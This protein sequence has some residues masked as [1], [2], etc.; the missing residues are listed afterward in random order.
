MAP[1]TPL[2][3]TVR[4]CTAFVAAIL[5]SVSPT[6]YA[7]N[8]S[9]GTLSL[10]GTVNF[11]T[12]PPTLSGGTLVVMPTTTWTSTTP[13]LGGITITGT[14]LSYSGP[15]TLLSL[16]VVD[17]AQIQVS[18]STLTL[19]S[20]PTFSNLVH[21]GAG[22]LVLSGGSNYGTG[23]TYT[24][25]N[26]GLTVVFYPGEITDPIPRQPPPP[27]LELPANRAP[28]AVNRNI[29]FSGAPSSAIV[30][31]NLAEDPD[32]D[33]LTYSITSP[34]SF[35]TV[36]ASLNTVIYTPSSSYLEGDTFTVQ[37]S[38]GRGGVVESTV[39]LFN[40]F[41]HLDGSYFGTVEGGGTLYATVDRFGVGSFKL[42]V[43]GLEFGGSFSLAPAGPTRFVLPNGPSTGTEAALSLGFPPEDT[44]I[45]RGVVS[46]IPGVEGSVVIDCRKRSAG[47]IVSGYAGQYNVELTAVSDSLKS[48]FGF[49]ITQVKP[50]GT[51]R[52]TGRLPSGKTWSTAGVVDELGNL[53]IQ[54]DYR[55]G[56]SMLAGRINLPSPN[57]RLVWRKPGGELP[58]MAL[59]GRFERQ[60]SAG[61]NVFGESQT[62][63]RF[64]LGSPDV[65]RKMTTHS[66]L[67]GFSTSASATKS[68]PIRIDARNRVTQLAPVPPLIT[69]GIKPDGRFSGTYV[70]TATNDFIHFTGILQSSRVRGLGVATGG[71]I[72]YVVIDDASDS[73]S[74]SS[75]S[76]LV[77]V[78][79]SAI[80]GQFSPDPTSVVT[81]SDQI[82]MRAIDPD[83]LSRPTK[84]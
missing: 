17:P 62:R 28:V 11:P 1:P 84:R 22:V 31:G 77:V 10:G 21:T 76:S 15:A 9:G 55:D 16:Q 46:G 30:I 72:G 61:L 83:R 4:L 39:V 34:A 14:P 25:V 2:R 18:G 82:S 36:S 8:F 81:G 54:L 37:C 59:G 65:T 7:Q 78:G 49:A 60:P 57:G 29:A 56:S 79:S 80:A 53:A 32:G 73:Q 38:D 27:T 50:D 12:A 66:D 63:A 71:R 33:W 48:P 75:G 19:S 13:D 44:S 58:L 70:A 24:L 52:T 6:T 41:A 20:N 42:R 3:L 23:G 43:R 74:G 35:G 45:L 64:S 67:T 47:E 69:I 26:Q 40:P 5:N 51:A 68:T